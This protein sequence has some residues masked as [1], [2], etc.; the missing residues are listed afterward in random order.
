MLQEG[1]YI[2]H[3]RLLGVL[4]RGGMGVVYLAEDLH[5]ERQ[6]AIKVIRTDPALYASAEEVQD[7]VR[8][9]R[10][11]ANAVAMLDHPHIL[12]L[13]ECSEQ[14]LNGTPCTYLVMPYRPEGSLADVLQRLS[15]PKRLLPSDVVHI[16][17]QAADALQHAHAHNIIHRDVKP[18]NFLLRNRNENAVLPDLLLTDFG[19]AKL[20]TTSENGPSTTIRGTAT[21]MAP[22][23]WAD[24]PEPATDQYALAIMA[25]ELLTGRAPFLGNQQQLMYQHFHVQPAPPSIFNPHISQDIDTVL[26]RALAKTPADRFLSIS[27]FSHALQEV[28]LRSNQVVSLANTQT[29]ANTVPAI[30]PNSFDPTNYGASIKP[31]RG[32]IRAKSL[33]LFTIVILFIAGGFG[34]YYG[35][36]IRQQEI[37]HSNATMTA[38][39]RDTAFSRNATGTAQ[40]YVTATSQAQTTATAQAIVNASATAQ[41]IAHATATA[42]AN[43]YA[44]ATAQASAT[45]A[46]RSANPNLYPPYAGTLALYDPLSDNS[47]GNGWDEGDNCTF[48]GGAYHASESQVGYYNPCIAQSTSFSN[49]VYEAQMTIISGDCGALIFRADGSNDKFYFFRICQD[50]TYALIR[51]DSFNSTGHILHSDSSSAIT[52]G[53]NQSNMIAVVAIGNSIDLYVNQQKIANVIDGTYSKGQIGVVADSPSNPTEVAF[54]NVRIW[55]W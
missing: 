11:E 12:P 28:V 50:G 6:V 30:D 49:F 35:A 5:V 22:E 40:S 47:Q 36:D 3:Y 41:A 13:Y 1:Q 37:E 46:I 26:L 55:T 14:V 10:R 7:A 43:A 29:I 54:S 27:A 21:Y 16:V 9:F 45:A 18:S 4:G 24:R 32:R 19:I 42:Q 8:L 52:T 44:T 51:Y 33:L 20:N 53:L 34:I 25:Y 2:G 48:T 39:V 23:Q 15:E 38:V 17:Q 31:D